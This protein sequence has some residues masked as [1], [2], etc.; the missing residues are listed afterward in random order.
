MKLAYLF[1]HND[2]LHEPITAINNFIGQCP[3]QDN[4]IIFEG[5]EKDALAKIN[6]PPAVWRVRQL[7]FDIAD[8]NV[9]QT[10][11]TL[12][13]RNKKAERELAHKP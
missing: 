5:A 2:K 12:E 4:I 1:E 6:L 9:T 10:T 8:G 7:A 13:L 11:L 3:A